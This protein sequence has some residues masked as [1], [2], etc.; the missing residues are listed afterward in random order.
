MKRIYLKR[1]KEESLLRFHPWIFSGAI[2]HSDKD[3]DE[4]EVVRVLTDRG[5]FIA[6]GHYQQGSIAVR[7]LT[8]NDVEID[9]QFWQSRLQSAFNMRQDIGLADRPDTNAYRLVHGEGDLLPGLIIDI[10]GQTAVMQ[11]HSIGMHIA[12]HNIA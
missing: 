3:I 4:G 10:Y 6:V 2:H 8:F 5:D 12:R 11:A 1:G 9:N 7:I